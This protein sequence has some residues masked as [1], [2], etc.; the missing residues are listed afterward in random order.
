VNFLKTCV[1]FIII[2]GVGAFFI[3]S[4]AGSLFEEEVGLH[5][6]FQLRGAL[7]PPPDVVIVSV[8]QTSST[9]LGLPE[10]PKKW[11]RSHYAKL[12]DQLKKQKPAIIAFDIY[13]S[14]NSDA[15]ADAVFAKAM[16]F[17]K[18]VV[19]A[20]VVK[21]IS[22]AKHVVSE[23]L[24][25]VRVIEPIPT[26]ANASLATA[27]FPLP[28]TSSTVKEYWLYTAGERPTLPFAIFQYF[29]I[30]Q[31]YPE[32]LQL[33]KEIGPTA[34]AKLPQTVE[35]FFYDNA[36][37]LGDIQMALAVSAQPLQKRIVSANYSGMVKQVLN[38]WLDLLQNND[39]RYLNYYGDV[40]AITTIPFHK[41]LAPENLDVNLFKNKIV[42][43]GYSDNLEPEKQQGFYSAFSQAT[44]QVISPTEIVATAVANLIGHSWLKVLSPQWQMVL[45]LVWGLLITAIFHLFIYRNALLV[46]LF[47]MGFYITLAS[48]VFTVHYQW[49][50][51]AT[52]LL[53]VVVIL[54]LQSTRHYRKLRKVTSYYLPKEVFA[55]SNHYSHVMSEY[56]IHM[57]GICMATDAG[58]YTSL[59]EFVNPL[60][61]HKLMNDYYAAIFPLVKKRGGIISDVIGDAMLAVWAAP[62]I[63]KK[64]KVNANLAALDIKTAIENFNAKSNY[65]LD[66]RVGLHYGE[67]RLGNI[68]AA[69]HFEYRAVGDTV[70]T[71]TRIEGLNK[72]L[73]TRILASSEVVEG[74]TGFT[75]RELGTFLLKGKKIPITIFE[76]AEDPATIESVQPHFLILLVKF[77]QALALFKNNN[78]QDAL[79]AFLEINKT[80]PWD[81]PTCFYISYLQYQ[82]TLPNPKNLGSKE[83]ADIIDVG[84]ITAWL[85]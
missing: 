24:D 80:Y 27:A 45:V 64:L 82:Q 5:W 11:P 62:K 43:V 31:A 77:G 39:R 68:G 81:G 3:S 36:E 55:I 49:L 23:E 72:L 33:L 63:E 15:Q 57:Q 71:A 58:Q 2:G 4:P 48:L 47:F 74:L 67:M 54:T 7:P 6:L 44:G 8:D 61:L 75:C 9:L 60:Q 69:D 40:G 73:G 25:N 46:V 13:F 22:G 59:S 14:E 79:D 30:K 50:P 18:N 83:R 76:L 1:L 35:K 42:L 85:Q 65:R 16:S 19:L 56:G 29:A 51:L 17:S 70:N 52:P 21:R 34:F 37:S 84:N 12:I 41:A 38:S 78:W 53:Q 26:L 66:T 10:E 28:K 20:S 32:L